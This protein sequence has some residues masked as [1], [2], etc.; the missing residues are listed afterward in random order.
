[1]MHAWQTSAWAL[2]MGL[3]MASL[4]VV[5]CSTTSGAHCR[6]VENGCFL[7]LY[8]GD[9]F[10][11]SEACLVIDEPGRYANL[12]QVPGATQHWTGAADS[13]EVG[14]QATVTVWSE[15]NFSG[16]S[17]IYAPGARIRSVEPEPAS[18]ELRCE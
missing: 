14:P 8:D 1:M 2:W 3:T 9:D 4:L 10:E 6:P 17:V 11:K 15:R 5:G 18:L 12:D 13:F 16:N 7:R